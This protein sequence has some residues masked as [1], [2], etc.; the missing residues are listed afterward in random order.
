MGLGKTLQSVAFSYMFLSQK[1]GK[2]VLVVCPKSVLSNWN[3][4]FSTWVRKANLKHM[5]LY[6]ISATKQLQE[7]NALLRAWS[8]SGGV[9]FINYELLTKL[10]DSKAEGKNSAANTQAKDAIINTDLLIVDEAHR[11]KNPAVSYFCDANLLYYIFVYR[12]FRQKFTRPCYK[13]KHQTR[14]YLL[15]H[16]CKID[17]GNTSM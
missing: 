8:K 17:S 12:I 14:S 6:L 3:S 5:P 15:V 9:A 13:L 1:C 11:V 7:R 10:I 4:E 16:H 2:T